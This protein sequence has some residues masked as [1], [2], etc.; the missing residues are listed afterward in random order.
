MK[1]MAFPSPGA[2][3]MKTFFKVVVWIAAVFLGLFVGTCF[4]TID[5]WYRRYCR[6][7][8]LLRVVDHR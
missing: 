1:W 4:P 3:E 6:N 2:F 7:I 5:R 8:R